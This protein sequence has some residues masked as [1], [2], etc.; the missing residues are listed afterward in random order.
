VSRESTGSS[1]VAI[2]TMR[3][4][5]TI[6]GFN[7]AIVAF[8]I[9]DMRRLGG[10]VT[11]DGFETSVHVGAGTVLL[12]GIA[13]SLAAVV[14]LISASVIDRDGT[15][16]PRMLLAG[17]LLMYLALAQTVTGFFSPYLQALHLAS[18]Q[19]GATG[20]AL[21]AVRAGMTA[22]GSVAWLLVAYFGP[23]V[24]LL[25]SPNTGFQKLLH[26]AGYGVCLVFVS[27][28]WWTA[29]LVDG[30]SVAGGSVLSAWLCAFAA[31]LYW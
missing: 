14:I 31:P 18:M 10:G 6:L 19:S 23:L 9:G 17:D 21:S 3:A 8:Q 7:L 30:T 15:C 5:L 2:N 27:H 1:S 16:D 20:E 12:T 25:R 4:R 26:V 24:S 29:Q 22:T 11:L 28:L 13:A